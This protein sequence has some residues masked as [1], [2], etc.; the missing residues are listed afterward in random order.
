MSPNCGEKNFI[1]NSAG[2]DTISLYLIVLYLGYTIVIYYR[3][4]QRNYILFVALDLIAL[5][6]FFFVLEICFPKKYDFCKSFPTD[7]L[8]KSTGFSLKF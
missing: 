6:Y 5:C 8:D 7:V 3:L 4:L 1:L 2:V